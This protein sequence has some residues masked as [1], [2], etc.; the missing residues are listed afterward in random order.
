MGSS[1]GADGRVEAGF[2]KLQG[3][4][5]EFYMQTYSI[6]LGRNSKSSSVDVDLSRFGGGTTI[7]RHHARIYYDFTCHH[8][9]L[10]VLGK[11]GVFVKGVL[12]FPGDPPVKLASQDLLQIGNTEFY[13]LLPSKGISKRSI[14]LS[15][16][17]STAPLPR[18][19]AVGA[20]DGNDNADVKDDVKVNDDGEIGK[21][22]KKN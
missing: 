18:G 20:K 4:D 3:K 2:A 7:S 12:H 16:P 22:S 15:I 13:F 21:G 9:A 5:F 8:F 6:L 14:Q 1:V 10:E 11:N 17:L 19:A